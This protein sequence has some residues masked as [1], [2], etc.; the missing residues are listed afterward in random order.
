M[1]VVDGV[2]PSCKQA[3]N[4]Q[5]ADKEKKRIKAFQLRKEICQVKQSLLNFTLDK[6]DCNDL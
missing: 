5:I 2:H 1:S 3:P 6:S 4:I